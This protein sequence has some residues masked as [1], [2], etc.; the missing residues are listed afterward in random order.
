LP[1]L[2]RSFSLASDWKYMLWLDYLLNSKYDSP[3]FPPPFPFKEK[4]SWLFYH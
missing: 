1:Y 4:M 2:K 3:L